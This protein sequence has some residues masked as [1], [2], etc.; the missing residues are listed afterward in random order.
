M[1]SKW[2]FIFSIWIQHSKFTGCKLYTWLQLW[3]QQEE[4][5][6]VGDNMG[7]KQWC[8]NELLTVLVMQCTHGLPMIYQWLTSG[9]QV[10]YQWLSAMP[11]S[12]QLDTGRPLSCPAVSHPLIY[13]L[14][15]K[16]HDLPPL[17]PRLTFRLV[18]FP[19]DVPGVINIDRLSSPSYRL[20]VN[21]WM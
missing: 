3:C 7:C 21:S 2:Q 13:W 16:L 19:L 15:N 17:V 20:S 12:L 10:V 8:E 9:L 18:R 11:A 6:C 14:F 4:I 5:L 1:Y